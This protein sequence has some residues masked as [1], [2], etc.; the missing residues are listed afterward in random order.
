MG[1]GHA[2]VTREAEPRG[3]EFDLD[4]L[5]PVRGDGVRVARSGAIEHGGR[6]THVALA[7]LGPIG[8]RAEDEERQH[9]PIVRVFRDLGRNAAVFAGLQGTCGK[10]LRP[11]RAT[12][13]AHRLNPGAS[14]YE[15]TW[16]SAGEISRM[17]SQ[18]SVMTRRFI[19]RL[20]S[21]S[22][23]DADAYF[24]D[25]SRDEHVPARAGYYRGAR[26]RPLPHAAVLDANH[27]SLGPRTGEAS[28]PGRASVSGDGRIGVRPP[29]AAAA[30]TEGLRKRKTT[31]SR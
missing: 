26:D 11:G 8:I 4:L 19:R 10:D 6:G 27:G 31:S 3:I 16:I 22:Q 9:R 15:L 1:D 21:T 5:E 12:F 23:A 20:D 30:K 25:S 18:M 7:D 2:R 29:R 24:S 28:H 14:T 13:V 17:D